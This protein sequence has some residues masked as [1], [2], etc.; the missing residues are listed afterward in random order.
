VQQPA[1]ETETSKTY[2]SCRDALERL[3]SQPCSPAV[4]MSP[5]HRNPTE[6]PRGRI[7]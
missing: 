4:T 6:M 5:V 3:G 2:Q 1:A 7:M